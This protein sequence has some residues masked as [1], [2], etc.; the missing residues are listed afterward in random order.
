MSRTITY[1]LV[2]SILAVSCTAAADE[3][4]RPPSLQLRNPSSTVT[5]GEVTL[6]TPPDQVFA[7]LVDYANWPKVFTYLDKVTIK[8]QRGNNAE[9]VTLSKKNKAHALRFRNDP[10]KRTLRFVELGGRADVKAEIVVTAGDTADTSV[11]KVR[12]EAE[13]GGMAG[14]FV[15]D[16]MVRGKRE[17]KIIKDLSHVSAY[18]NAP[19]TK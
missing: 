15:S 2:A 13:V 6:P 10:A 11:V 9:I 1:L 5:E 17:K 19:R 7:A 4:P 3:P 14:W 8:S 18:F 12:L 16:S